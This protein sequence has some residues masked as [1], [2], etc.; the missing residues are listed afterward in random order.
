[1]WEQ[2]LDFVDRMT[3]GADEEEQP[4]LFNWTKEEIE[5]HEKLVGSQ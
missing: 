4:R 2:V 5:D 3:G 1:M